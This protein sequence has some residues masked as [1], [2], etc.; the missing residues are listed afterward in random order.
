M[1]LPNI[2]QNILSLFKGGALLLGL[3]IG[4]PV[5]KI[6]LPALST[7]TIQLQANQQSGA[8]CGYHAA[9]NA[10]AIQ[11]L[12]KAG[13]PIDEK[14]IQH[15]ARTY[16]RY[17]GKHDLEIAEIIIDVGQKIG[18]KNVYFLGYDRKNG[19]Y[20]A[21]VLNE[22]EDLDTFFKTLQ[23]KQAFLAHFICNTGGHWVLISLFK[24][25][26]KPL[27]IIYLD[28]VNNSLKP[29]SI[30]Y[31]F[32]QKIYELISAKNRHEESLFSRIAH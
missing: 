7:A 18:L 25:P 27:R 30:G 10:K 22:Q 26:Q 16:F 28:S 2:F 15:Q 13:T 19:V 1:K 20:P 23:T 4:K 14:A 8:T 17:L 24:Q 32:I 5:E 29:D 9:F 11:D 6:E 12:F 21:G 31:T 3:N